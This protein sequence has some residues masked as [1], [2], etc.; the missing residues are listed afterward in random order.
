MLD[1]IYEEIELRIERT[2]KIFKGVKQLINLS[3]PVVSLE[4]QQ[5]LSFSRVPAMGLVGDSI[6]Y[7]RDSE[8]ADY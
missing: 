3:S 7:R 6:I 8:R 2:N 4:T 1:Q 5:P